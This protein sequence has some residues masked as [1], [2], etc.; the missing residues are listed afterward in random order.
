MHMRPWC[1]FQRGASGTLSRTKRSASSHPRDMCTSNICPWCYIFRRCREHIVFA[2]ADTHRSRL[3]VSKYLQ[4][5]R[6]V[7]PKQCRRMHRQDTALSMEPHLS[8]L[9]PSDR[10]R[11]RSSAV[12]ASIFFC[13]ERVSGISVSARPRCKEPFHRLNN[14]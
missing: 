14:A 10:I 11:A 7:T 9:S 3:N 12:H 8:N 2:P 4:I 13:N 5:C 6:V 1:S